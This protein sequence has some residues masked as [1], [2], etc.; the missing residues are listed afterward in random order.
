MRATN[1]CGT[2]GS[3][4]P[5]ARG[6]S[7]LGD[8]SS[9]C[10]DLEPSL[11]PIFLRWSSSALLGMTPMPLPEQEMKGGEGGREGGGGGTTTDPATDRLQLHPACQRKAARVFVYELARDYLRFCETNKTARSYL[12]KNKEDSARGGVNCYSPS[13]DLVDGLPRGSTGWPLSAG[14]ILFDISS[15]TKRTSSGISA[16]VSVGSVWGS[17]AW[18]FESIVFHF[19]RR[20]FTTRLCGM[21]ACPRMRSPVPPK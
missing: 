7:A 5:M 12:V 16:R 3:P 15:T 21:T 19:S 13:S 8:S 20:L 4:A 14:G 18:L 17:L 2:G 10:L 9:S 6:P 1:F 11:I